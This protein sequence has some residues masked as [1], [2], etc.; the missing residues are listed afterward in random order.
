MDR[1]TFSWSSSSG[2]REKRLRPRRGSAGADRVADASAA[3]AGLLV[4]R[5]FGAGAILRPASGTRSAGPAVLPSGLPAGPLEGGSASAVGPV[6]ADRADPVPTSSVER[7][8]ATARA[9]SACAT[10]SRFVGSASV[11]V[12]PPC[13]GELTARPRAGGLGAAPIGRSSSHWPRRIP[14][15]ANATRIA[16]AR[17]VRTNRGSRKSDG[18]GELAEGV[19]AGG[20]HESSPDHRERRPLG[21]R[22]AGSRRPEQSA[23]SPQILAV[24]SPG[25]SYRTFHGRCRGVL[26]KRQSRSRTESG[27]KRRVGR[28]RQE[29]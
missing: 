14:R 26:G 4:R 19:A 9:S 28:S 13:V 12:G 15:I 29:A 8:I 11:P 23:G 1:F 25:D 10:S 2:G 27:R 7:L 6:S 22:G 5:A 21:T 3:A 17:R 16:L 20:F 24:Q 18:K